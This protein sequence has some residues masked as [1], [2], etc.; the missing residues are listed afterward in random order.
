MPLDLT[1]WR[2][3]IDPHQPARTPP[4]ASSTQSTPL[5]P[6]TLDWPTVAQL[7]QQA[8]NRLSHR[9]ANRHVSDDEQRLTGI[10]I[11]DDLLDERDSDDLRRGLAPTP[12]TARQLLRQAVIDA[13]F[14]LGRLQPLIDDQSIENIIITGCDRVWLELADGSML[15]GP[16]VADS[17]EELIDFLSFIAARSASTPRAFAPVEPRLHLQLADGSRLA[18]VAW[19]TPRPCVVIRRHR[20][21]EVSL[22]DLVARGTLSRQLADFLNRAVQARASIVVSGAQGAGKTT[23]MRALCAA[24]PAQET[25]GTFETEYELGLHRQLGRHPRV[26]AWEARPGFGELDAA[27]QRPGAFSLD[28]ALYDSFRFN[29]TR[30]IVGE[31]RGAEILPMIKAMQSGSGSLSTTHARSA[32]AAIDKLITCALESGERISAAFATR[33]ISGTIDFVVHI[34]MSDQPDMTDQADRTDQAEVSQQRPNG[35]PASSPSAASSSGKRPASTRQRWVSQ[36]LAV[37]PSDAEQGYACTTV[38]D[39]PPGRRQAELVSLPPGFEELIERP[40][41]PDGRWLRGQS[42][43]V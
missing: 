5:A 32:A 13:V 3:R 15:T 16:A 41:L 31:V 4:T 38:F 26:I 42:W 29:L 20:L 33:A 1:D 19:V 18:A 9:L 21:A 22:D 25:I 17:D 7:R 6:A 34:E 28:Q 39:C 40:T 36:V 8:S 12:Q 23:L 11:I 37:K 2:S 43:S 27:G 30:Q 10:A 24:I 35:Q 14:G